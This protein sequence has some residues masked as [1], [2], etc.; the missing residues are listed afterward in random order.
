MH[1]KSVLVIDWHYLLEDRGCRSA[2]YY[3]DHDIICTQRPSNSA[4]I[5]QQAVIPVIPLEMISAL[6][7]DMHEYKG[8]QLNSQ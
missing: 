7:D 8:D 1:R 5:T 3:I 4:L 2:V 6:L